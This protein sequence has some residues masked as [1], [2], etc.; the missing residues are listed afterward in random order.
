M[1]FPNVF[2]KNSRSAALERE[3]RLRLLSDADRDLVRLLND[4]GFSRWLEQ[5]KSIGGCARPVYLSG[6]TLTYDAASGEVV[7]S[8]STATEPGERLAVR[9]RNRR[10]SVCEPCSRLHA[11]DTFHLVRAG[12]SGG[13]SVPAAVRERP[14]LFVTL[15]APSFGPVHRAVEGRRCRLRRDDPRCE[16]GRALSCGQLHSDGDSLTGMPLCADCYDYVGHVLWH[17][18]AGLLWDR[19]TTAVRRH[20]ASAAGIPRTQLASH[21]VVSFAKVAE[22]QKRAAV[23][24]HAVVRLDGP[25]GPASPP[26]AWATAELLTEAVNH[27]AASGH[28]AAPDSPAYGTRRLAWG[29][30]FDAR[31]VHSFDSP[32]GLSDGAVAG[33]V[34]KYVSK[35]ATYTGAG[36]DY[37][38]TSVDDIRAAVLTPHARALVGTS[39]RLGGLVELEH[40]RLRSWAHSL[41]YRGHI[42]TK[43]RRYS[44]TYGALREERAD[45]RRGDTKPSDSPD[46][47]TEAAWRYVGSGYTPGAAQLAAGIAEDI[48]MS[49]ELAREEMANEGWKYAE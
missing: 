23:H 9:C 47:V 10:A 30:Q 49:R 38:I 34:A 39:W 4:P 32:D 24:F 41:G 43:S 28:V 18:H 11:G 14:R 1:R 5:I 37:R 2:A 29:A 22:F 33:Y 40:L 21:V 12:L 31:P 48:A 16:H 15:T 8:Y 26:P 13:K 20:L 27:A 45:H 46:M 42:L 17:A 44:T 3:R 19:F 7:S 25:N 6:S 36:C 35:G